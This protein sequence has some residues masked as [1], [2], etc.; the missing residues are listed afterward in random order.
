M[1]QQMALPNISLRELEFFRETVRAGSATRAADRLGVSQPAV[2]RALSR[3]EDRFDFNL[4]RREEGRL[5]PTAAAFA[6][7]EELDPVFSTLEKISQFSRPAPSSENEILRIAAP[8]TLSICLIHSLIADFMDVHPNARF[9][10]QICTSQEVIQKI[11]LGDADVGISDTYL[12]HEGIRFET[13]LRLNAVCVLR[14]DDGLADRSLITAKD[15]DK[16]PMIFMSRSF[17]SRYALERVFEKANVIPNIIAEVTTSY[18]ACAFISQGMGLAVLNPFPV[19]D[20][21]FDNLIARPFS[22][23]VAY[24]TRI[25][26][27]ATRR[28]SWLAQTFCAFVIEQSS[29]RLD[30]LLKTY[31]IPPSPIT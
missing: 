23:A 29:N 7:I 27:P 6:L 4:F 5:A 1:R 22:P 3:L 11:A 2:S 25:L 13:V 19:L 28:P 8:T 10:L 26:T 9:Q 24:R 14:D 15:L 20:G 18:A 21:P 12:T 17:S 31:T 16:R 30:R